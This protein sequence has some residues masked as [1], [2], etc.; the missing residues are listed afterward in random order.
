MP[1]VGNAPAALPQQ[2]GLP[3]TDAV[4]IVQGIVQ[5]LA[6]ISPDGVTYLLRVR[7][8]RSG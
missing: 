3:D 5:E 6:L 7:T 4:P 2:Q 1:D 8:F